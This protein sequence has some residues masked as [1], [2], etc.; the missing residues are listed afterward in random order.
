MFC[1]KNWQSIVEGKEKAK[2]RGNKMS[3][4]HQVFKLC[5]P[6]K[7]GGKKDSVQDKV[8]EIQAEEELFWD[9]S[10]ESCTGLVEQ[11][12]SGATFQAW[13]N[14]GTQNIKTL[15]A[16]RVSN[17]SSYT[18]IFLIGKISG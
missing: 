6:W 17:Q 13:H 1:L 3:I 10:D 9:L 16:S 18:N 14:S 12:S 11:A 5:F 4:L 2:L 7:D 8:C 15:E